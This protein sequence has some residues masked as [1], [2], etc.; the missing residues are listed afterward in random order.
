MYQ[1]ERDIRWLIQRC[2]VA[3]TDVAFSA[4]LSQNY[5]CYSLELHYNGPGIYL[6][7]AREAKS[8]LHVFCGEKEGCNVSE[9]LNTVQSLFS[10]CKLWEQ[11][12][13][14]KTKCPE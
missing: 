13:R 1:V 4:M 14:E 5:A 2:N 8:Q 3:A 6:T 11:A 10:G 9:T 12:Y 7:D